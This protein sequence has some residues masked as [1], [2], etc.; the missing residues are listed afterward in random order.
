VTI[1]RFNSILTMSL[2]KEPAGAFNKA[3]RLIECGAC[4]RLL[5]E[6]TTPPNRG[7]PLVS[8]VSAS[9]EPAGGILPT[10]HLG[11]SAIFIGRRGRLIEPRGRS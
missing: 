5:I 6:N 8:V 7:A 9:A 2:E 1:T 10:Y 11:N 4:Y 3:Q